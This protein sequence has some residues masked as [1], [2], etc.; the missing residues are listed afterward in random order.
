MKNKPRAAANRISQILN[1]V[2]GP[3]RFPVDVEEL[4]R[5]YSRQISPDSY[6]TDIKPIPLNG[7]EGCLRAKP[8]GSKWMI[9][10]NP[11]QGSQGRT[12][13]TLAHE[14]GH[15]VL[16]RNQQQIFEC[17]ER[18]MYDW[19]S[20]ARQIE[21]EADTF[22]SYLL[23]PL[24]DYRAQL[25]GQAMNTDLLEHCSNRYGVSIMAAALKWIEIAPRRVVV[26]AARDGFLLW[27]RSNERAFKSKCYLAAS[28]KTIEVPPQS[29]LAEVAENGGTSR[30]TTDARIW[31][32][33]EPY[34]MPLEE[35][36]ICVDSP[37][38]PYSLGILQMPE[39]ERDNWGR[40]SKDDELLRP[41]TK[42]KW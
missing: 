32:P 26:V 38:F 8:D 14:L 11:D 1:Q 42:P 35:T 20:P 28:K 22:S 4:A 2:Y 40:D 33:Q 39:A 29:L 27:A 25:A 19:D 6:I 15:F 41:L 24:D 9:A 16:H 21:A 18:D 30:R 36:A 13:F 34:G 7:F 23:M 37:T 5:E 17:S 12:R 3:D 31:F 10:Y